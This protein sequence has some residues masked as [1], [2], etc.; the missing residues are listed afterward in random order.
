[1]VDTSQSLSAGDLCLSTNPAIADFCLDETFV[2]I[3]T[4]SLIS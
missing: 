4:Q 2:K 3:L 1:M